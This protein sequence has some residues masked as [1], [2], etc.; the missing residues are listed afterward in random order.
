[1]NIVPFI[2]EKWSLIGTRLKLPL[3]T[4]DEIWQKASEQQIPTESQNTFCCVKMLTS[5]YEASDDVSADAI[6]MAVDAPHVG[7]KTKISSIKTALTSEYV[8]MGSS[9]GISAT[10]PPEKL[11]QSYFDMITKFCSELS[12]LIKNT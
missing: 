1:M 8:P 10:M 6:I 12:K 2:Q 5:W 7:L 11:E 9:E 4:L 3:D